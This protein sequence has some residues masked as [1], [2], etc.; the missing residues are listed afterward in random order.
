M[1][2]TALYSQV[3]GIN[4]PPVV[5]ERNQNPVFVSCD[6]V[7]ANPDDKVFDFSGFDGFLL[8]VIE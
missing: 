2:L 5:F 8:A 3:F 4:T 7:F 6:S 1:R